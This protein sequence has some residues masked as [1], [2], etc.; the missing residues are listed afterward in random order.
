[1][2]SP[3]PRSRLAT[4]LLAVFASATLRAQQTPPPPTPPS[5]EEPVT[6]SAFN[7]TGSKDVGYTATNTL[8]GT[9]LN[10]PL[11]DVGTEIAFLGSYGTF[12]ATDALENSN[13][14]TKNW[15]SYWLAGVTLPFQ[16]AKDQKLSVG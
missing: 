14:A 5:A 16:V 6:L 4:L 9:R 1:M 3:I 2:K 8:A 12:K 10:T 7:V 11:K 13:P 15:G